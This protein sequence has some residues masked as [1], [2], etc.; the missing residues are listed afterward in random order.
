MEPTLALVACGPQIEV[1]LW[2]GRLAS[3]S[4]VRL[5]GPT[6]RSTL[7]L[8][9]ADL[10]VEDAGFTPA[11]ITQVV[12][13]RGPGSFTGIRSALATAE[14]M[15]AASGVAVSAYGSLEMQAARCRAPGD[16]WAAQPGRRGEVYAR[17]F[18]VVGDGPPRPCGDIEIVAVDDVAGRG[19]WVA[20][21]A[22]GLGA[23]RRVEAVVT[24]A[25]ALLRLVT[26]D[27][28]VDPIEPLYIEGPP[29]HRAP[30]EGA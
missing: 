1:G 12:L 11:D 4:V 22:L 18:T 28:P 25:E 9:A 3:P 24:A 23:A 29:I 26:W 13:G 19:P 15:R 8:A 14:G 7:L 6:P 10:V 20:F 17:R 27:V 5:S 16:V 30:G 21:E 2:G